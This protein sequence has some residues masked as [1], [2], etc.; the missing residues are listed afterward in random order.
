M[1]PEELTER[2]QIRF[3]EETHNIYAHNNDGDFEVFKYGLEPDRRRDCQNETV[4]EQPVLRITDEQSRM[5]GQYI[6]SILSL[7][8]I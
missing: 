8:H 4:A 7:I 2:Y 5:L 6:V 1:T 3:N